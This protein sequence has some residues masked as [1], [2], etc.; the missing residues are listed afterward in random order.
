MMSQKKVEV[1]LRQHN[2]K[3]PYYHGGKYNGTAMVTFMTKSGD[4]MGD[5][6]DMLLTLPA[7]GNEEVIEVTEKF[8]NVLRVFDGIFSLAHTPSGQMT[9]DSV[10]R[11]RSYVTDGMKYWREMELS[12]EAPKPHA[13]EDHLVNQVVQFHGY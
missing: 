2:I 1:I 3:K 11:L 7:E 13:I 4:I 10:S 9:E 12:I 6:C 8:K 5:L